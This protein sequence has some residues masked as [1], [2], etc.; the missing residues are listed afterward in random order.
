MRMNQRGFTL[1]EILIVVCLVGIIASFSVARGARARVR[2]QN[3]M[4]QRHIASY[5]TTARTA[6]MQRGA[7]VTLRIDADSVWITADS[8]GTELPLRPA[9]F[10]SRY[11]SVAT[12]ATASA[13]RRPLRDRPRPKWLRRERHGVRRPDRQGPHARLR[14]SRRA[15]VATRRPHRDR[16][17]PG[18][19]GG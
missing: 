6:A 15:V 1:V 7:V 10:L 2:T 5:V 18:A 3:A 16:R 12:S 8:S 9:L 11:Y 19:R 17:M 4:A 13:D 14:M